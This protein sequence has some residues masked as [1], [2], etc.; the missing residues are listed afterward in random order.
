MHWSK[1][2]IFKIV[3]FSNE[4]D[5]GMFLDFLLE[6][7]NVEMINICCGHGAVVS[8]KK[9]ETSISPLHWSKGMIFKIVWCPN[10]TDEGMFLDFLLEIYNVEMVNISCGHGAVVSLKKNETSI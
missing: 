10:E 9:N 5:E 1:G 8:F 6:I 2:M 7:Y 4:T 3:W